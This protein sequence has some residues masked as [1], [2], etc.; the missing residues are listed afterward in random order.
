[1]ELINECRK[2]LIEYKNNGGTQKEAYDT[3]LDIIIGYFGNKEMLIWEEYL[4]T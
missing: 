1:M 4:R 2:I 3:L